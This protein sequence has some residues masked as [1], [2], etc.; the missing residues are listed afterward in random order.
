MADVRRGAAATFVDVER[1]ALV[2]TDSE[3]LNGE[4]V[5]VDIIVSALANRGVRGEPVIWHD[6]KVAWS[7]YDLVVMRSPWDYPERLDEFTLWLQGVSSEAVVLN[8]PHMILWNL[9]KSYLLEL[10]SRG[11][12]IVPTAL[13]ATLE[14]VAAAVAEAP[15]DVVIK[16]SVSVGSRDT[17]WFRPSDDGALRLAADILAVGKKVLVQPAIPSVATEGEHA[18]V[19]FDGQFSHALYKGPIL[20]PGGGFLGGQYTEDVA[21][22]AA[23]EDEIELGLRAAAAIADALGES[24][25]PLYARFDVVRS[26]EGPRLLEAELFEPS[27]FLATAPGAEVRFADAV[28]R[29]LEASTRAR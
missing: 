24:L 2:T 13:C 29:R 15:G 21:A 22:V 27:Y 11:I 23:S 14:H 7:S 12:P 6:R 1:V 20:A 9:D 28:V 25:P 18:L 8:P 10:A 16:P 26:D 19:C 4:D 5:D 17:G 3:V